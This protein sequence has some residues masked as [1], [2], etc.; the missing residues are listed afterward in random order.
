MNNCRIFLSIIVL[1]HCFSLLSTNKNAPIVVE[2]IV[3]IVN[4]DVILLTELRSAVQQEQLLS[5]NKKAISHANIRKIKQQVLDQLINDKLL[6]QQEKKLAILVSDSELNSVVDDIAK[7]NNLTKEEFSQALSTRGLTLKKYKKNIKKEILRTKIFQ[8][9]LKSK[10]QISEQDIL[11]QYNKI[12]LSKKND[13]K[14]KVRHILFPLDKVKIRSKKDQDK[15]A[16]KIHS[17][18][19]KIKTRLDFIKTANE[20]NHDKTGGLLGL[21]LQRGESLQQFEDA[22]FMAQPNT[23]IGPIKTDL[24]YHL[25]WVDKRIPYKIEPLNKIKDN[26]QQKLFAQKSQEAFADF[27]KKL[28]K[29]AYI[30]INPF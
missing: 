2:K 25:I 11:N 18:I 30:K 13:Y 14:I 5:D 26:L 28:R 22:A 10:V 23:L 27:F 17:I 6:L 9:R 3:A 19:K 8:Q 1:L 20:I 7:K 29:D 16:K 12:K 24:G 4:N 15:L 21:E